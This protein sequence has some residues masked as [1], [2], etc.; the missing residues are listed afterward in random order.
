M[1]KGGFPLK[2]IQTA[3][4]K[5]DQ[6][7]TDL[8]IGSIAVGNSAAFCCKR[9][10]SLTNSVFSTIK[11][12]AFVPPYC[13]RHSACK[14]PVLPA[15]WQTALP[16]CLRRICDGLLGIYDLDGTPSHQGGAWELFSQRRPRQ[17][18][19]MFG[20]RTARS[21]KNEDTW[22][23]AHRHCAGSGGVGDHLGL[24]FPGGD[25]LHPG[26]RAPPWAGPAPSSR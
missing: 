22:K 18:N 7:Y 5:L 24:L 14:F 25:A 10:P 17:V 2:F 1:Q 19:S 15:S 8:E 4:W 11:L 13:C 9:F 26:Q 20:Y 16:G 6:F 12:A 23:F 21:M 3:Q